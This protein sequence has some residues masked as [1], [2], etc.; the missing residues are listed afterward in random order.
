LDAWPVPQVP[1]PPQDPPEVAS[2]KEE[3]QRSMPRL[4]AQLEVL[5]VLRQIRELAGRLAGPQPAQLIT[6]KR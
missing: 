1:S 6:Q 2:L 3:L 5:A 4:A